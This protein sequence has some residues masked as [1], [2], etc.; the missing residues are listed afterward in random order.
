MPTAITSG[1]SQVTLTSNSFFFMDDSE[2]IVSTTNGISFETGSTDATL[3]VAGT[4][5]ADGRGV[6]GN[7]GDNITI[8][9]A[10]SATIVAT[11]VGVGMSEDNA[12]LVNHGA[13]TS[14]GSI[15]VNLEAASRGG[16]SFVNHGTVA[17][18]TIGTAIQGDAQYV[19]NHGSITGE[20]GV[21]FSNDNSTFIN[22][23]T[24]TGS[25]T[26]AGVASYGVM[27]TVLD[28]GNVTWNFGTITGLTASYFL[29]GSTVDTVLHNHG[30]MVGDVLLGDRADAYFG[31]ADGVVAG[32]ILG[33][34][35]NDTVRGGHDADD[36]DGG[37]DNDRLHG[38]GGDDTILGGAGDDYLVAGD[39]NDV[40]DGGTGKDTIRA[41]TGNDEITAGDNDDVVHAGTGDDTVTGDDG[42]DILNGGGGHD[43]LIGGAAR[44]ILNGGR[45]DDLLM[46]GG[47]RDILNGDQGD[48]SLN[49]GNG[50]DQL[51]GGS[52]DDTIT[53][54]I[55]D[56]IFIFNRK[57][58]DDQI[59]DFT[60]DQDRIDLSDFDLADFAEFNAA[61]AVSNSG[62][63]IT[64]DLNALGGSGSITLIDLNA[65]FV[66]LAG[67]FIF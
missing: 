24:V 44:D 58:G 33:N 47:D 56:D 28:D 46:G 41:G 59:T 36:I 15:G 2:T 62:F 23:G 34:E 54:G 32:Q 63:S 18:N 49:G 10:D 8:N 21:R 51:N 30:L 67:D 19:V 37:A 14:L 3:F 61:N 43:E 52:G 13:V 45:E 40:L 25:S 16:T 50:I 4:I 66:F 29:D 60:L 20:I 42:R 6:F 17:G 22:H 9:I 11:S 27:V 38:R 35:G 31:G 64:I 1:S 7:T 26:A 65:P 57:A 48:D 55:G 53:G 39:G 5:Y 12:S